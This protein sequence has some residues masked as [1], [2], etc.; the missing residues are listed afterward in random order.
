MRVSIGSDHRGLSLKTKLIEHLR[1]LGH[2]VSDEGPTSDES[3]DYP[4]YAASVG[5]K[6]RDGDSEAGILVCGTG[7]GMSISANKISGVR[8]ALCH[9]ELTARRSREHNN[10]NV[11]CLAADSLDQ[12]QACELLETFLATPFAGG[13]HSRRVEKINS[14]DE[15]NIP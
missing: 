13:R 10:S 4:D 2:Q 15:T 7:I 9:D 6:I 8:A 3:V 11:L 5:R 14:L 12:P 1:K